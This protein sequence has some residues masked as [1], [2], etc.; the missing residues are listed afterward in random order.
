MFVTMKLDKESWGEGEVSWL[1]MHS[2][3]SVV[4]ADN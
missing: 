4:L 1:Y 3:L 2:H